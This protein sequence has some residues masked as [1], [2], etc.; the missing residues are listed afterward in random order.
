MSRFAVGN[1]ATPGGIILPDA[2]VD[3]TGSRV[4]S[5]LVYALLSPE[6]L[7]LVLAK[8]LELSV[9]IKLTHGIF[10]LSC[11]CPTVLDTPPNPCD[12][13]VVN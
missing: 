12:E 7:T 1:G 8:L 11:E 13:F 3:C 4:S 6:W 2:S 5:L 10:T 9:W